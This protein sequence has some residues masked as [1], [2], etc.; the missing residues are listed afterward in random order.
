MEGW[1]WCLALAWV[2]CSFWLVSCPRLYLDVVLS[3]T[4][5]A[6]YGGGDQR[7][8]KFSSCSISPLSALLLELI[9]STADIFVCILI[10]DFLS[11]SVG[12]SSSNINRRQMRAPCGALRSLGWCA[13]CGWGWCV[14]R[15]LDGDRII[16]ILIFRDFYLSRRHSSSSSRSSS[17]SSNINTGSMKAACGAWRSLGWCVRFG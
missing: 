8:P 6:Q 9:S 16:C 1:E 15:W 2:V 17:S 11:R 12:S 3:V 10:F 4:S 7:E 14:G 13:R 5:V